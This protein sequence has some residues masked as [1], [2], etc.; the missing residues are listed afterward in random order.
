[1]DDRR[2]SNPNTRWI[3]NQQTSTRKNYCTNTV[4]FKSAGP[5]GS[6][7]SRNSNIGHDSTPAL[8]TTVKLK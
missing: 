5:T 3:D 2:E 6:N 1:M 7:V 8:F 4:A